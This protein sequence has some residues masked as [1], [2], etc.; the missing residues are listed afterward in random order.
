MRR[1]TERGKRYLL[2]RS[3]LRSSTHH[4]LVDTLPGLSYDLLCFL[5]I[6]KFLFDIE[7]C[8][9]GQLLCGEK[10]SP[11]NLQLENHSENSLFSKVAAHFNSV[12]ATVQ[13]S[14]L[15]IPYYTA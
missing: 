3:L 7:P 15:E 5:T 14:I 2:R 6:N 10:Q 11:M 8:A 12:D 13:C 4:L 1:Q 9:E